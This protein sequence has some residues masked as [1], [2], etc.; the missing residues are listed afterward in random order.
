VALLH[1]VRGRSFEKGRDSE[2]QKQEPFDGQLQA[3]REA[4]RTARL[5]L[6]PHFE[7]HQIDEYLRMYAEE[8][9]RL[10]VLRQQVQLVCDAL[11]GVRWIPR[12]AALTGRRYSPGLPSESQSWR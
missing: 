9:K 10:E 8:G 6:A 5:E 4:Y 11:T 7:P 1:A 2:R 12:K 3:L